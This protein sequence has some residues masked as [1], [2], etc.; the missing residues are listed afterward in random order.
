MEEATRREVE[1]FARLILT[2]Y[3]CESDVEFLISTFTPDIVWF[4]AGENQ[5]A[6]GAQAVAACFREGKGDLAPCLMTRERYVSRELGAGVYLCEGESF[7]QP[8]P[9]TG[10]YFHTHQRVTFIFQRVDGRLKTAHI[11][12]SVSY[13]ALGADELFPVQFGREAYEHL[14]SQLAQKERE[15]DLMLSQ[16]PGGMQICRID[17]DFTTLWVSP[18][19]CTLLGFE[20]SDDYAKSCGSCR[21]FILQEDY[22]PMFEQVEKA[23]AAGDSYYAEYRVRRQDG[24]VIWVGDVGKRAADPDGSQVLYC[25]I[26]DITERKQQELRAERANLEV[27]RQARFLSRLY[28]T[29][30]CGILQFTPDESHRIVSLNRTTWQFYGFPSE[31]AYREAVSTPLEL[32]LA[33]EREQVEARIASLILDGEPINY[34]RE[35]RLQSGETAYIS[36]V[37]QRLLSA[38]GED[39]IQAVFTDV[40]ETRRLQIARQREQ[41]IENRSL[42]AAIYTAYPLI[43]SVNLTR[44]TYSCFGDEM[45]AYIDAQGGSFEE[46]VRRSSQ[47]VT[48]AYREAFTSAFSREGI[49]R[50]FASGE[51]EIYLEVQQR[52]MDGE[53]HWISI[54]LIY[55]DNPVGTD[56]LAI[57]LVKLLDSQRAEQARQELLLRDA[58]AS[59]RAANEAKSDFL[60]RMS[61]DIRT[62]MNAIIGMSTIGQLKLGDEARVRD[63]FQKIDAS[64]RYL[65]SLIN[66]ILD[67]SKIETGKMSIVRERFDFSEFT[68]DLNTI[69]FP[70]MLE[71]SL[72]FEEHVH[73]PLDRFYVGDALRLKQILMNLLSNAMKFT[74][75]GGSIV[76]DIAEGHRQNGFASLRFCV[77]DTGIGMSE[78]FMERIFQPF[79]QETSERARNNV[80]SGLGLSIVYNLVQLMGGE[81]S[82]K[83]RQG[84]GSTFTFSVPLG[85]THEDAAAE[86]ARK[87]RELLHGLGVLVVDDDEVVGEQACAILADIGAHTLYVDSGKKAVRAVQDAASRGEAFDIAMID[88]RMPDMDGV[89][90]TRA[91]RRLVGPETTIIIIS[92]YDWSGIEEEARAA[93]ADCFIAKPLL[94]TTVCE[95]FTHLTL[96]RR[97]AAAQTLDAHSFSGQRVLLVEDNELNLEIARSL[98][99]MHGLAVD[100]APNGRAALTAFA[101]APEGRYL[102]ILMDIRMPVMDG[103]EATRAI[104]AL[105]RPDAKSVP[106]FAMTANAFDE[107][108]ALARQAGMTGYLVKPLDIQA[109]LRELYALL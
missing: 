43:L 73:E 79:E 44:D 27:Q 40:T 87:Q 57:E 66:D 18:S 94:R 88:W 42:R 95:T 3:F 89:E 51:R 19:L 30:P 25:F 75:P 33:S 85:L 100:A 107:D 26:Y 78:A 96:P 91:I 67:M 70:Q 62:P 46:L 54:H 39:V 92:A 82:V 48:P 49:L 60:S 105:D 11:H 69:L 81:I 102:A 106:I 6:E 15:V 45:P 38:D 20:D 2:R 22:A 31:A 7:I 61:H 14:Q 13:A 83:S 65:L 36:V 71:R 101:A 58:L 86:N 28:D 104:R 93:G 50:R 77:S 63:C 9:E 29:V 4:G 12:N 37:M 8:R 103:L 59:A 5:K 53:Y 35:C 21:G 72:R 76:V 52:G 99:E 24:Q 32:V 68:Q 108:R 23:F 41:L 55:V 10:L 16:L 80:G 97:P 84:E 56:V 17:E 109:M 1:D 74:H 90:T 64:S 47:D 98:L 34:T